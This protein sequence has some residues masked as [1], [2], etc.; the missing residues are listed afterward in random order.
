MMEQPASILIV[1]DEPD[2]CANLKDI[3]TDLGYRVD[4]APDGRAALDLARGEPYDVA[5]L[6]LKMPGMDGL[7]L[8]REIKKL[9]PGTVAILITAYAKSEIA[10]AALGAGAWKILGKPLDLTRLLGLLDE[11]LDQPLVLVVDDDPDFCAALWDLLRERGYRVAVAHG[12]RECEGQLAE[13]AS[14]DLAL[15]DLKLPDG[16]GG[17]VFR[18]VRE[19]NPWART[20]LIT[21]H[22][23]EMEPAIR[24]ILARGADAVVYK[25]LEVE[26]LVAT[27]D[28]LT[29]GRSHAPGGN[30]P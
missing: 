28:Q 30:G 21:A 29:E 16:D 1:D 7:T 27:L 5:L 25:P 24:R 22:R 2:I 10:R 3:L 8:Y 14:Y 13:G 26:A 23:S 11:A 17:R 6:D 20:V 18:R 9:R 15:I 12:Q 19:A 4:T